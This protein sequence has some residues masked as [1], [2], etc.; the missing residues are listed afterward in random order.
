MRK[1]LDVN[2]DCP[3][4]LEDIGLTMTTVKQV[5]QTLLNLFCD[6]STTGIAVEPQNTETEEPPPKS[7][8]G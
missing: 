5:N 4:T 1:L 7:P 3:K 6:D 2:F 8:S